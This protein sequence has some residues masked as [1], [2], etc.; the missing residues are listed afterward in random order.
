M[1]WLHASS[2]AAKEPALLPS[3]FWHCVPE[4]LAEQCLLTDIDFILIVTDA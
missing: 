2:P 1:V 3:G 4:H